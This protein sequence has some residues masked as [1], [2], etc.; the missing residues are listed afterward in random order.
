MLTFIQHA[1]GA[2]FLYLLL[3]WYGTTEGS[4]Q[5][6][7]LVEIRAEVVE[8]VHEARVR[9]VLSLGSAK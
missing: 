1:P 2:K 3:A 6:V 7:L 4:Q 5:H 9:L 8:I